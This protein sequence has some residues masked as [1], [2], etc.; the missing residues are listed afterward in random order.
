MNE[1]R[2]DLDEQQAIE[3]ELHQLAYRMAQAL[4]DLDCPDC[5]DAAQVLFLPPEPLPPPVV[6]R[7]RFQ[8]QT[9]LQLQ[10]GPH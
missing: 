7:L 2:K 1:P 8:H 3:Q 6:Q 4:A 9:C 10:S 5:L